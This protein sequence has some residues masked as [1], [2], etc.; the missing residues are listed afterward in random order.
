M[1]KSLESFRV[2]VRVPEFQ[3][4]KIRLVRRHIHRSPRYTNA[5]PA[6]PTP[7]NSTVADDLS[8]TVCP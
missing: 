3:G 7:A 8:F 2:C 4:K 5:T 6:P 1:F